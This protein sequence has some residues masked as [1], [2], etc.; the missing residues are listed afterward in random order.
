MEEG[1]AKSKRLLKNSWG[2]YS[3][4]PRKPGE[5]LLD[6]KEVMEAL[7][8]LQ[9][10]AV[11]KLLG[12]NPEAEISGKVRTKEKPSIPLKILTIFLIWLS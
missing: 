2:Y 4:I 11:G 8:I 1:L 3:G 10:E 7:G 12:K 5:S 6:G 9:G